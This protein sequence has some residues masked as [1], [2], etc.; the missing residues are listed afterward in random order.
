MAFPGRVTRVRTEVFRYAQV[1]W[2]GAKEEFE[3]RISPGWVT[4][5]FVDDLRRQ[6]PGGVYLVLEETRLVCDSA[7]LREGRAAGDDL[8]K[9]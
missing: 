6:D 8:W 7:S 1:A 4:R 5:G 2:N 3:R 9:E